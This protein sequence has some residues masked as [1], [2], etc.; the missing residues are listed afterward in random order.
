M[1][2]PVG[3]AAEP[4]VSVV[5]A[6]HNGEK[7]GA[8]AIQSILDQ[9]FTDFEFIIIDD[10]STDSTPHLL[11]NFSERDG[12]IRILTNSENLSVPR[13]LN[14]GLDTAR[15]AYIARMDA[16]DISLPHRL[17]EQ[18]RFLEA[19]RDFCL[20]GGGAQY[21]DACGRATNRFEA[22]ARFWEFE[23]VSLFRPPLIHSSAMYRAEVVIEKCERYDH[24]FNRAADFEF[25]HRVLRH[26]RGCEL[27]G[28][29]IQYR[30]HNGNVST[31]HAKKQREV[32]NRASQINARKHFPQIEEG[33]R[34]LVFDF[35]R[36][37]VSLHPSQLKNVIAT[38]EEMQSVFAGRHGLSPAQINDIRRKTAKL[39]IKAVIDRGFLHRPSGVTAA[40]DLIA[41]YFPEYAGD[42]INLLRR[43]AGISKAA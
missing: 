37:D 12:R 2:Q 9:S 17:S 15:G 26:G 22:G 40:L 21:I 8:A 23:W 41:R 27:P 13:S 24:D 30:V 18:V 7:Y 42:T 19:N 32:A 10:A 14:R 38:I 11:R 6:V 36:A 28:V 34:K 35:L 33:D 39:L 16:D 5:M 3:S 25:W 20:V 4:C 29:F 31:K 1:T 43:R